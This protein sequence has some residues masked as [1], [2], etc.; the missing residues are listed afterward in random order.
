[1]HSYLEMV[2]LMALG[3]V[4]VLYWPPVLELFGIGGRKPEWPIRLKSRPLLWRYVT[5]MLGAMV[6]LEWVSYL[7]EEVLSLDELPMPLSDCHRFASPMT[8]A[9]RLPDVGLRRRV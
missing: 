2:P 5:A 3:F 8:V 1:V 4:S 7:E 9:L 6:V